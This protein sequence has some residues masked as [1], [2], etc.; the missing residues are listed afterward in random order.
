MRGNIASDPEAIRGSRAMVEDMN[1]GMAWNN[2]GISRRARDAAV[3]AAR[4]QGMGVDDWLDEAIA[5][6]AGLDPHVR[7]DDNEAVGDRLD[8]AAGRLER[9]ARRKAPAQEQRTPG[10]SA[11]SGSLIERFEMRLAR[12]EAQAARAFESVAQI[13]ERDTAARD[14][15]RR[16]LIDAV[17]RLESIRANLTGSDQT[18]KASGDLFPEPAAPPFDLKAAVSQIA[19]GRHELEALA[20]RGKPGPTPPDPLTVGFEADA[21]APARGDRSP[22]QRDARPKG[23]EDSLNGPLSAANLADSPP[24][25]QLVLDDVRALGRKLD[26]MRRE[27]AEQSASAVDLSAMRAEI[28]AMSR[29]LADL[30]PR[31]AVVALEGAIRDLVQRVEMLR[32]NGHGESVLAPLEAMA[33]EFRAAVKAHDPQAAAAGLEREIRAIDDKISAL[34]RTAINAETFE[35]I[36]QQTEEVRNL[37]ASAALRT[38]PLE[39]LERQIGELADRVE[40]LAASPTPH[41]ESAEMAALL[42]DACRQIERSTPPA[43]LVSIEQR[44]EQ[45]AARLDQEIARPNAPVA[46]DPSPFEELARRIDYLR[47]SLDTRPLPTIDAGP[48]EKLL[49]E[50]EAKLDAAA[51]S[52]TDAQALQSIFVDIKDKLDHLAAREVG[53]A[54]LEPILHEFGAR[55]D[56]MAPPVD[57][58]PIETLLRSVEARVEASAAAPVD[59]EVVEQVADEVARR[60]RDVSSRPTDLEVVARQIDTIYDRLD[61]LAA[62]AAAYDPGPVARELLEKLREAD[63]AE[64]SSG[65]ET[66][67]AINAALNSQFAELRAQQASADQRTQSRLGDLQSILQDS[68]HA[69]R[70]HR[71]RTCRRR[72]R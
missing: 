50:F 62:N 10:I 49:R 32:Q 39:R 69:S 56:A 64:G 24:L 59:R 41:F 14:G 12:A 7:A 38:P 15:D 31:N 40:Q 22:G 48:I 8:A 67:T 43:V 27:N 51:R 30:A 1:R 58:N 53:A 61:A 4:R 52:D 9:I 44:L 54:Q 45:I 68:R 63:G 72:R 70:K 3:E 47:Q 17:R 18:R 46:I 25:T 65:S 33:A 16:A 55:L 13:L 35:R 6:Y 26:E 57:L 28:D 36:R 19:M 20:G 42:A 23:P 71:E 29:S 5:D 21:A 34:S 2:A 37:L 11:S 66:S 60:L